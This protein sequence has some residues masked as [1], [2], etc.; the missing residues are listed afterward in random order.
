MLESTIFF[1]FFHAFWRSQSFC[2]ARHFYLTSLKPAVVMFLTTGTARQAQPIVSCRITFNESGIAGSGVAT[3][4]R[5]LCHQWKQ[6]TSR[7]LAAI[8]SSLQP[9]Q[10]SLIRAS[11]LQLCA[12]QCATWHALQQYLAGQSA[13]AR[14]GVSRQHSSHELCEMM[15]GVSRCRV[16]LQYRRYRC[17]M[18]VCMPWSTQQHSVQHAVT[19]GL[20]YAHVEEA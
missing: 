4:H 8:A 2:D 3:H 19:A 14:G 20:E 7:Y 17:K 15:S 16:Y 18:C 5:H 1:P 13:G 6:T 12:G 9:Q 10:L 11:T